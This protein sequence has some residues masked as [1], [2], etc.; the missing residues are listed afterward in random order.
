MFEFKLGW[1]FGSFYGYL[2]RV[3][4]E[5]MKVVL[6]MAITANGMIADNDDDANWLTKEE[7]ASY[8]EIV[9]KTGCLIVGRRT[10]YILTKQPEFQEFK[11]AKLVVVSH[12]DVELADPRHAVAHSPKEA[13]ALLSDF[14]GVIVAGGGILNAAFLAED[15]VDEMYLD[16]EPA[17]LG[18]GIPLFKGRPFERELKLLGTKMLSDNEIQLHYQI[19]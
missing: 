11:D 7:A 2:F 8:C 16:I 14:S 18:E 4:L 19:V 1:R 3:R 15:L 9:R 17:I 13:V 12:D 5:N 6:Y 10:Y